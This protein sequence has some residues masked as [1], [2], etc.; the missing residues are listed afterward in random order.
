MKAT[1]IALGV[2]CLV[3][4]PALL[5]VL[6]FSSVYSVDLILKRPTSQSKFSL[7]YFKRMLVEFLAAAILG[8]QV[9]STALVTPCLGITQT[10]E[11]PFRVQPSTKR[12]DRYKRR[13]THSCLLPSPIENGSSAT[14]M[15]PSVRTSDSNL[16]FFHALYAR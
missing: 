4:G 16:S 15:A 7:A 12:P 9:Q 2:L 13:C 11:M 5:L 8:P 3:P 10:D 6:L 1:L 14:S